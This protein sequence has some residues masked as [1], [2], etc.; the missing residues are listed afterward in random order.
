LVF[1]IDGSGF[2]G[3]GEREKKE[4]KERENEDDQ[5]T[6]MTSTIGVTLMSRK[7]KKKKKNEQRKKK[8]AKKREKRKRDRYHISFTSLFIVFFF[9]AYSWGEKEKGKKKGRKGGTVPSTFSIYADRT[10]FFLALRY[11]DTKKGEERKRVRKGENAF[12]LFFLFF[13][14]SATRLIHSLGKGNGEKQEKGRKRGPFHFPYSLFQA[15]DVPYSF[16]CFDGPARPL[17]K[18]EREK[19]KKKNFQL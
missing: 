7:K 3:R 13:F 16:L 17:E 10:R 5:E 4:G 12:F 18:G 15:S 19:K 14:S 8:R 9:P 11:D 6:T 1:P 2:V